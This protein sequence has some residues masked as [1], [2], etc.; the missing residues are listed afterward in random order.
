MRIRPKWLRDICAVLFSA[1]YIIYANE[2]DE[3]VWK[4][5]LIH[6]RVFFLLAGR[7]ASSGQHQRSSFFAQRGRNHPTHTY[8][9]EVILVLLCRRAEVLRSDADPTDWLATQDVYPPHHS[10]LSS[11]FLDVYPTSNCPPLFCSACVETCRIDRA[12]LGYTRR[13]V[14]VYDA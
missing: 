8:V 10:N 9:A 14:C 13:R 7:S 3:K 1:Y 12:N 6:S 2:A 4:R 11:V 5:L